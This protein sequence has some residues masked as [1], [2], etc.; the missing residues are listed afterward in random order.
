MKTRLLDPKYVANT[1]GVKVAT[2]AQW[3]YRGIGPR[4]I[5]V[6]KLVRYSEDDLQEYIQQRTRTG[7]SLTGRQSY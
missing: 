6:G 3:R 2:L 4:F 7:T 5:K 1:V